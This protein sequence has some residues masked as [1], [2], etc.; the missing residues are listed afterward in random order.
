M[1][2]EKSLER[3]EQLQKQIKVGWWPAI[4]P[5]LSEKLSLLFK[6]IL[7]PPYPYYPYNCCL[8]THYD[9]LIQELMTKLVM[10]DTRSEN[11]EMDIG[12]L[13]VRI[14]KVE[15][16]II[17]MV[18]TTM[19]I[20]TFPRLPIWFI[21]MMVM[22]AIIIIMMVMVMVIIIITIGYKQ[23]PGDEACDDNNFGGLYWWWFFMKSE[24]VQLMPNFAW[25]QITSWIRW[26]RILWWRSQRSNK[27]PTI[28]MMSLI[29]WC[30]YN[31]HILWCM[32]YL[33]LHEQIASLV[34][35]SRSQSKNCVAWMKT[36]R[37]LHL[38]G[39]D[40]VDCV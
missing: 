37:E 40:C 5:P 6:N 15:I 33:D 19:I 22:M 2:E 13:N 39:V 7:W 9:Q 8:K 32:Y 29:L 35:G 26:R 25:K 3:E 27:S 11:A 14:D 17:M 24:I 30:D 12:R 28:L 21:I 4:S 18:M 10:A 36:T 23:G 16:I 1:S 20:I 34:L 38:K 31:S